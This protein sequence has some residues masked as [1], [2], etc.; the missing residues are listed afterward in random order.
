MFMTS[1]T[2]K[3][4]QVIYSKISKH[5]LGK[6]QGNTLTGFQSRYEKILMILDFCAHPVLERGANPTP[7]PVSQ[8][9]ACI[10]VFTLCYFSTDFPIFKLACLHSLTQARHML[11]CVLW[12]ALSTAITAA[13]AAAGSR[14]RP[15]R[16][17][18][19]PAP[20]LPEADCQK[21]CACESSPDHQMGDKAGPGS[22]AAS[23]ESWCR[24]MRRETVTRAWGGDGAIW[25]LRCTLLKWSHHRAFLWW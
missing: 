5:T 18:L 25:C 16:L 9:L 4:Q 10:D 21:I 20:L 14:D 2:A 1:A 11:P 8:H 24:D 13:A 3:G 6:M 23:F 12:W 7:V 19:G 17:E 15:A 22:A